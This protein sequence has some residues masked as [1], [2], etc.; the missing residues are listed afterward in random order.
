MNAAGG[1]DVQVLLV[2]GQSFNYSG[3]M[4]TELLEQKLV[5]LQKRVEAL[6][7][8]AKPVAKAGWR[9]AIGFAKDDALFSEAMRL[10]AEWRSK[11]NIEGL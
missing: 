10:G 4:S 6:E 11:A 7:A 2:I 8:K 5:E 1:R 3:G 9:E